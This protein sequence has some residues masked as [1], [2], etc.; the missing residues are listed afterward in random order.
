[1]INKHVM[2]DVRANLLERSVQILKEV[3]FGLDIVAIDVTMIPQ[4]PT[5]NGPRPVWGIYYYAKGLLLGSENYIPQLTAF[6]DPTINDEGLK[7][8]LAQGC[9]MLRVARA[10][11][12]NG[13]RK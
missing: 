3:S 8:G 7:E 4:V 11:Q 10:Q 12:G 2:I 1:V 13:A 5:P 6:A 9:E